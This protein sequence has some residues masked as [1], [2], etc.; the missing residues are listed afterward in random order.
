MIREYALF[1]YFFT[2]KKLM[3]PTNSFQLLI[4]PFHEAHAMHFANNSILSLTLIK[5][6]FFFFFF[7]GLFPI[8]TT[9]S[10]NI[11]EIF[12]GEKNTVSNPDYFQPSP[13]SFVMFQKCPLSSWL[14]E[15]FFKLFFRLVQG[16]VEF[17]YIHCILKNLFATLKNPNFLP[18]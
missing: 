13:H 17:F 11:L 8:H 16:W 10:S 2:P 5:C 4:L 12:R 14:A 15:I 3:S 7:L 9:H 18:Q 6:P 1:I